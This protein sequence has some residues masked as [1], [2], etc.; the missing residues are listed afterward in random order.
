MRTR[1]NRLWN[2]APE[3]AVSRLPVGSSARSRRGWL[4]KA[5]AMATRLL[6]AA[7]QLRRLMGQPVGQ[8]QTGQKLFS[9]RPRPLPGRAADHLG[10][11]H[12]V[13]SGEF[14]QQVVELIDEAD[15]A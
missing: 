11:G 10:Q 7:R 15:A 12:V 4:A 13:Q 5:R 1:S 2:T 3:V 9:P 6:L 14:G 8:T